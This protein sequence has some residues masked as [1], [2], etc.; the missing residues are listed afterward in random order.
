VLWLGS[1]A[2][3]TF[4]VVLVL[5]GATQAEVARA[6]SLDLAASG[7][8]GAV[9]ALG[10]GGGVLIGGPLVDRFA[11][12]PLMAGSCVVCALGLFVIG[13]QRSY[14]EVVTALIVLGIGC[15]VYDTLV[16]AVVLEKAGARGA[17][18][19]ALVHASAT[20][21]ASVGPL[22]VR[23]GLNHWNWWLVFNAVGA[24]HLGLALAA[25]S[26]RGSRPS[27]A[28]AHREGREHELGA[29]AR[30]GQLRG[31]LVSAPALIAIAIATC[32]YVGLENGVTL[33]AVPWA[34][35]LGDSEPMGQWSI[36]AF[37]GGLLIGRLWLVA[38]GAR[39]E[40][41]ALGTLQEADAVEARTEL[42]ALDARRDAGVQ[43]LAACGAGGAV[44][45]CAG[46][47][48]AHGPLIVVTTLAGIAL[49]P[50][51]PLAMTLVARRVPSA[52]GTAL[53]LVASAGAVGGFAIPWVAGA[54]G[55]RFGVQ[56]AVTLLG[57]HGFVVAATAVALARHEAAKQVPLGNAAE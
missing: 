37:W 16:N 47:L 21:G 31:L 8:L 57:L 23:F 9:L 19:L 51:Y 2:F 27:A 41:R 22:L 33:Y 53:G 48:L 28:R 5:L 55:D 26:L 39:R 35:S 13:P 24:V 40:A 12:A 15:G 1:S 17:S 34:A 32:A 11:R 38:L 25:V 43:L 10:I 52:T 7:F 50:V 46:A 29:G 4:G 45:V 54:V 42:A 49:G 3:F 6:L 56:A 36:S 44:I 14:V 30:E 18:A 20:L